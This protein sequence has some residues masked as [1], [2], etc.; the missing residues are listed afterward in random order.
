M[1]ILLR[2]EVAGKGEHKFYVS[3]ESP[4]PNIGDMVFFAEA[5]QLG[6]FAISERNFTYAEQG[7]VVSYYSK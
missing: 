5:S 3:E 7:L 6:R 1:K 4:I 2:F